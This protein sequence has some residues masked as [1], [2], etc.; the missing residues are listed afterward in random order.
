MGGACLASGDEYDSWAGQL[1]AEGGREER[2][3]PQG[4]RERKHKENET[5]HGDDFDD[6]NNSFLSFLTPFLHATTALSLGIIQGQKK[7]K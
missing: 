6:L 3:G 7:K 4:G 5:L 1:D 2:H